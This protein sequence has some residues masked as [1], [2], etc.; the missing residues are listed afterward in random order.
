MTF[1]EKLKRI[2]TDRDLSQ[3][4]LAS[5]LGTSKQVISRYENDQTTPK[6]DVALKYSTLLH[7]PLDYLI[8][9]TIET[10]EDSRRKAV[11]MLPYQPTHRIPILGR[12]SAGLP[13]YAEEHI[14]GFTYTELNHGAE[15]F[16]LRV[17]G[18]SMNAAS[19]NDGNLIIVR[20]QDVV[21]NGQVAVVLIGDEDA[22]VKRFAQHGSI[23]TLL[24]QST[25]PVHQPQI[26]DLR[27]TSVKI[28]GL[29]IRCEVD[30]I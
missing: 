1:G 6:I 24:P 18:D 11:N 14:E 13:L 25:N 27:D 29:V 10:L 19:I 4:S 28:L 22:T 26:Y 15:Y 3:D 5:I 21:E 2:R 20:R 16:A 30:I 23:V 8:D 7:V 17:K 9:D 12:I